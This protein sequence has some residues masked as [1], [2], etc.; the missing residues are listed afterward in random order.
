MQCRC[1][2]LKALASNPDLPLS[3]SG[4]TAVGCLCLISESPNLRISEGRES[5]E[6][7]SEVSD[8]GLEEVHVEIL[9][10]TSADPSS[11]HGR[12]E[13]RTETHEAREA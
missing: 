13:T 1:G 5:G 7:A 12:T 2:T 6:E 3:L 9:R 8:G 4:I 10:E 11:E